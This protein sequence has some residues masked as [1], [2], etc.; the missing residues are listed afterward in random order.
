[1]MV[2]TAESKNK[3]RRIRIRDCYT[4]LEKLSRKISLHLWYYTCTSL[5]YY[6]YCCIDEIQKDHII[7]NEG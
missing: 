1:M 4:F 3:I 7:E 5:K 2:D 6:Y